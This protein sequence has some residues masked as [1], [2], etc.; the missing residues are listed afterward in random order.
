MSKVL[1]GLWWVMMTGWL[2]LLMPY[3]RWARA[4]PGF[5]AKGLAFSPVLVLLLLL[6][7]AA[8]P[9][10]E[11]GEPATGDAAVVEPEST[12]VRATPTPTPLPPYIDG[13]EAVDVTRNLE[14]RG[15]KCEGPRRANGYTSWTCQGTSG[16][17]LVQLYVEVIGRSALQIITVEATVTNASIAS[18]E[19]VA[20]SFLGYVASLPYKNAQQA[21]SRA[22][23]EAN[24]STLTP[25]VEQVVG[26]ARY[27][28]YGTARARFLEIE[29]VGAT[30]P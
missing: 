18:T 25:P 17:G 30:F 6:A 12:A 26:S 24:V 28:L 5:W 10:A 11:Q 29:A 9:G 27:R 22:W 2:R 14:N 15:L 16:G 19:S 13:L 7:I 23:A 20:A 3:W 1:N 21:Q 8:L 4:K